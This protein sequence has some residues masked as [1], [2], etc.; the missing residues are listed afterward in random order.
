MLFTTERCD[1]AGKIFGFALV[2]SFAAGR[3]EAS[4]FV[5]FKNGL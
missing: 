5:P 3:D 4:F 1:V 2:T